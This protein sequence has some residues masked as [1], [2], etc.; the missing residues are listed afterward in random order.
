[1][2]CFK[3]P[4]SRWFILAK[5]TAE[6]I[7][8][9]DFVRLS[10]MAKANATVRVYYVLPCCLLLL[11]LVNAVISYQAERIVSPWL[12]TAAVMGLVL[13]GGSLVAFFIAPGIEALVRWLQRTLSLIHI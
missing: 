1:L 6:L 9:H 8:S 11:N 7:L 10:G 3:L 5:D 4:A 2:H 13:F 12:R